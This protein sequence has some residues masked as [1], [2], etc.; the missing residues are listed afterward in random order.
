MPA[1]LTRRRRRRASGDA[2][3]ETYLRLETASILSTVGNPI[4]YLVSIAINIATDKRRAEARRRLTTYEVDRLLEIA[5]EAP[6]PARIVEARSE[7]LALER[8]FQEMP[9]RRRA[10]VKA[11]LIEKIPRADLAKRFGVSIRTKYLFPPEIAHAMF[12]TWQPLL[13]PAR[14][15]CEHQPNTALPDYICFEIDR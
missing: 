5:D 13:W 14:L 12:W 15:N 7:L 2:L 4:N 10:I 8:A 6:D 9:E 1:G 11:A 3:Q